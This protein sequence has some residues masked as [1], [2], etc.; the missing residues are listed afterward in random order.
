M[1]AAIVAY[2]FRTNSS[3]FHRLHIG[4]GK[5]LLDKGLR[6]PGLSL[7]IAFIEELQVRIEKGDNG[8]EGSHF[9]RSSPCVTEPLESLQ[10]G[11]QQG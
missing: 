3:Y 2:S 10:S 4:V 11:Q 7:R 5:L 9:H 1:N 6:S 8:P